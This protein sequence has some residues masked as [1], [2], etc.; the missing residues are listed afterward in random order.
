MSGNEDNQFND[1]RALMRHEFL[2]AL[3]RI[4]ITKYIGLNPDPAEAIDCLFKHNVSTRWV[5]CRGSGFLVRG[6]LGDGMFA[7]CRCRCCKRR[8]WW[9]TTTSAAPSY[10][11]R[12]STWSSTSTTSSCRYGRSAESTSQKPSQILTLIFITIVTVQLIHLK[13][14]MLKPVQGMPSFGLMEWVGR[15]VSIPV[16]VEARGSCRYPHWWCASLGTTP[17]C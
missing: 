8:C 6:A 17:D 9:R 13:Y 5:W 12:R 2:D 4:A 11:P 7:W 3:I 10:T 16:V 15:R 1:D 14:A